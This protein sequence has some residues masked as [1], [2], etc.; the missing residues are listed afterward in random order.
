MSKAGTERGYDC[1]GEIH[2]SLDT[3]E[4]REIFILKDSAGTRTSRFKISMDK[5]RLESRRKFL[6]FRKINYRIVPNRKRGEKGCISFE[7]EV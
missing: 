1:L 7:D 5:F 3:R 4:G 6:T 2:G